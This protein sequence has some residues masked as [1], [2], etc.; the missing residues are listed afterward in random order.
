MVKP[1]V[2]NNMCM[3]V[4]PSGL[5]KPVADQ[6]AFVKESMAGAEGGPKRVL[7]L[8]ASGGYG[9]ASRIAATFGYGADTIGVSFEREPSERRDGTPGWYNNEVFDKLAH[10][11]GR[12][13][14]SINAD[15]FAN[16]TREQ[17]AELIRKELGQVDLVVYSLASPVRPD[18]E[19]GELYRST[20]KPITEPY[21]AVTVDVMTGDMKPINIPVATE[22][23]VASTVKVMGGEDW[24]LWTDYLLAENLLAEGATTVAYSYIGPEITRLIYRSGALGKAKQHLEGTAAALA[25]KLAPLGGRAFVSVNKA[26]VTRASAVI[27]TMPVY[28]AAL[29]K[30]MKAKGVHEGCIEQIV[31][32]FT[33]RLYG[34]ADVLVDEAGRI[35]LDDW[36]MREDVQADVDA[37]M[38]EMGTTANIQGVTDLVG[39]RREFLE[40]HGFAAE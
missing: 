1:K 32:L 24:A 27:P 33:D 17:V 11:A 38:A 40:L 31:R 13:A 2:R 20:I 36:E 10:E 28:I 16:A 21:D 26:L 5:A 22:E 12:K 19:T 6:I 8:G 9:L 39:Y 4:D 34:S 37:I 30:V 29:Y 3:N 35:R 25:A 23:E 7:I 18:P 15:A 14:V